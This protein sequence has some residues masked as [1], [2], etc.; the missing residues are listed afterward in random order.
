MR[1]RDQGNKQ[2]KEDVDKERKEGRKDEIQ[3]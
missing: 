3:R 2:K 1:I